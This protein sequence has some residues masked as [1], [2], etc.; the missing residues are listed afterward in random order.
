V[1]INVNVC[2]ASSAIIVDP[3]T[4]PSS[5]MLM[6]QLDNTGS[7]AESVYGFL[8]NTDATYYLYVEPVLDPKTSTTQVKIIQKLADGTR[9][10]FLTRGVFDCADHHPSPA[11]HLGFKKCGADNP[12]DPVE[13][14]ATAAHAEMFSNPLLSRL[15]SGI[16]A[17]IAPAGRD[18][19]DPAWIACSDGCCTINAS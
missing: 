13:T 14:S 12:D 4:P 5:E 3:K 7:D 19:T 11:A 8:P 15:L 16:F 1:K 18:P 6:A 17:L 10:D 2:M 9:S